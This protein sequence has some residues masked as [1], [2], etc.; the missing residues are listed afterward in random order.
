MNWLD[1]KNVIINLWR[2]RETKCSDGDFKKQTEIE[3]D[4][5]SLLIVKGFFFM[6]PPLMKYNRP[7]VLF[8]LTLLIEIGYVLGHN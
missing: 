3:N 6:F 1:P 4:N 5:L 2:N 8:N 7:R